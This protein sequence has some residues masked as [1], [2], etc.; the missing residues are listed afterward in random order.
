MLNNN[1]P[2]A[3]L[4][5]GP[6]PALVRGVS[7][8]PTRP[9]HG[10]EK[11]FRTQVEYLDGN[12]NKLPSKYVTVHSYEQNGATL[13]VCNVNI[14]YPHAFKKLVYSGNNYSISDDEFTVVDLATGATLYDWVY[15]KDNKELTQVPAQ[16]GDLKGA[17]PYCKKTPSSY[18]RNMDCIAIHAP[19][20]GDL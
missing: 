17:C 14:V 16:G 11:Y 5:L 18:C 6:P 15:D 4:N 3:S 1:N 7:N 19:Y 12:G 8:A 2:L 13:L 9:R 10:D 20:E